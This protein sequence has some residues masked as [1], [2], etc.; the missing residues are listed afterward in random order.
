MAADL[1]LPADTAKTRLSRFNLKFEVKV[2]I[3]SV[4]DRLCY[5]TIRGK[6][7]FITAETCVCAAAVVAAERS[8]F[9]GLF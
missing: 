8:K 6:F 4:P 9:I 7:S 2:H 3:A 1:R 5:A